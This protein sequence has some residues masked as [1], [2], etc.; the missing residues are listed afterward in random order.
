MAPYFTVHTI[1]QL[2]SSWTYTKQMWKNE[3]GAQYYFTKHILIK[4]EN[5]ILHLT[6]SLFASLLYHFHHSASSL[7][8]NYN[9]DYSFPV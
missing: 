2:I 4:K 5:Q 9:I 6:V 7:T 1:T 3:Q 8:L